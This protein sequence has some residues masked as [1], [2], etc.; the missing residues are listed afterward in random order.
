MHQVSKNFAR[1]NREFIGK[2]P[3]GLRGNN[4][5][6]EVASQHNPD[7]KPLCEDSDCV[8]ITDSLLSQ[9]LF[10]QYC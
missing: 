10:D 3:Q 9:L 2:A 8:L 5:R 7:M 6:D 4:R 1:D